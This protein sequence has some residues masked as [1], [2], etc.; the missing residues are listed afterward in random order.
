MAVDELR[1]YH[2][3]PRFL[4]EVEVVMDEQTP[5]RE[6]HDCGILLQH[7]IEALPAVERC[8]VHI[9]YQHRDGNDHDLRTPAHCKVHSSHPCMLQPCDES[10]T[11]LTAN[12]LTSLLG[13]YEAH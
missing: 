9:D 12:S 3:G 8:F 13:E 4:V 7:K 1:A 10:S 2:F 6:S 11:P 5:L